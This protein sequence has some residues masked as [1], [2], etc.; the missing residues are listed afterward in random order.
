MLC[1]DTYKKIGTRMG[2]HTQFQSRTGHIM[3][4]FSKTI[5]E[6]CDF[7]YLYHGF[8]IKIYGHCPLETLMR[9]MMTLLSLSSHRREGY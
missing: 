5:S 8:C 6:I 3:F 4:S 7:K 9:Q 1:S 2:I